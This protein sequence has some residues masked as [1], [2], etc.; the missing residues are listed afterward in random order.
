[1]TV[2]TSEER[3]DYLKKLTEEA[4]GKARFWFTSFDRFDHVLTFSDPLVDTIWQVASKLGYY[5][6]TAA[7]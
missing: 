2:T 4:G 1:M 7:P 5:S 3:V 6:P